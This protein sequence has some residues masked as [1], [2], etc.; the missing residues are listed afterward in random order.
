MAMRPWCVLGL[1]LAAWSG[2][3]APVQAAPEIGIGENHDGLFA[4]PLFQPLG[5]KH[6]RVVVSYDVVAAAARGDDE[7]DRVT[8]YLAAA[9]AGGQEPLVAFEHARG[10]PE[11]CKQDPSLRVCRLP[12][13]S[14]YERSFNAFRLRFPQVRAFTPWN[15]ANHRTQPTASSPETAA[16]F[17]DIAAQAC[18]ECTIVLADVLDQAERRFA[19]RPTY[20]RT[21]RWIQRFRAA[22]HAPREVCGIHNYSDVNR[23]RWTGT[24]A[25]MRALGCRRY[26]LTETG[27]IVMSRGLA[28]DPGRQLRATRFLL[29]MVANEPLIAR[30]YVYTWFGG[31]TPFW[32]SGLVL[33][34]T[35]GTTVAR[36]AYEL[37]RRSVG[38]AP[39][40]PAPVTSEIETLTDTA[41]QAWLAMETPDNFFPNPSLPEVARGWG[42]FAPPMLMYALERTGERR[43][44]QARIAG[45]TRAWLNSV[46]AD[47]ASPFDMIGA[48]YALRDLS[49][50]PEVRSYLLAYLQ[51]YVPKYT[52]AYNNLRL[53]EALAAI[54]ATNAGVPSPWL[55]GAIETINEIAPRVARGSGY[56]SDP[57]SAPLAYHALSTLM[58]AEA[59]NA[60]GPRASAAA[61]RTVRATLETL[62]RVVAPDGA[63][64][65][66]GRGQGNVWVPA[67]TAAA[68]LAGARMY[69]ADAGHY[70]AVA[71]LALARLRALHL[72]PDRGL[73]VVPG[74][75]TSVDG[76]DPYVYT[77]AY[78]GLALW[79]LTLAGER[80]PA[81]P[82]VTAPAEGRLAVS[83]PRASG[84]GIVSTGHT[85][86]AVRALRRLGNS[87]LRSGFGLLALKVVIGGAWRDL[88]A[89]RPLV[90]GAPYTPAPS[91]GV[92]GG[93][94]LTVARDTIRIAGSFGT[95][96]ARFG[97][98]AL[99][100]GAALTVEPVRA[101][102]HYQLYVFTAAGTGRWG[103]RR[104]DAFGARWRFSAPVSVRRVPGFH[105]GPVEH[106]DA[107]VVTARPPRAGRLTI[108]ISAS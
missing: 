3:V 2:A 88:L 14:E 106:L 23:F 21:Q 77:V 98:R 90:K 50:T 32:D 46:A 101:G 39:P 45:A 91:R 97:F 102:E 56:L 80:A 64:D 75:R 53:V 4:D 69:P 20:R 8:R 104:L 94:G 76:V 79:A 1:T 83:E 28:H 81:A 19:P 54:A 7:L 42:G 10:D 5:I 74:A 67:V 9:A 17:S 6:V 58:L 15:E 49:L 72:T 12:S 59:V 11:A 65:Y 61:R 55:Y 38:G 100:D 107:L 73:L 105:S 103:A 16:R 18:P 66:L 13:D 68:M 41:L 93:T 25:L 43:G 108:R 52:G 33:H 84:L 70:I 62:S 51:A 85:W 48:A 60:L 30:V 89:P 87:D 35:D 95:R 86:L 22:L 27:G 78:N 24:R 99:A 71:R 31:V 36:P 47:H 63:A 40:P 57:G 34:R 29:R 82:A 96:K 44:D 37:L 92:P 26:W